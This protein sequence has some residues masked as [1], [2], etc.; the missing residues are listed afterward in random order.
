MTRRILVIVAALVFATPAL[1]VVDFNAVQ[2]ANVKVVSI[3]YS[4]EVVRAMALDI[5]VDSNTT[6]AGISSYKTGES[7]AASKGYG[8]FPGRFRDYIDAANP[9]WADPNYTPVAPAGDPDA[10]GGIGTNGVT[11]E[12]GSLYVGEPNKPATSGTLCKLLLSTT[13]LDCNMTVAAN[14][15]RGR[16]V[17]EDANEAST[18]LSIVRKLVFLTIPPAPQLLYG[19]YDSDCNVPVYWGPSPTATSYDLE[20][21]LGGGA[22]ANVYTG[23][24]LYKLDNTNSVVGMYRYRARATN[25]IGPSA[26]TTGPNE[27]NVILSTC[28]RT[29]ADPN[30]AEWVAM[31]RPRCWCA[32]P[33]SNGYQCDG[34][35]AGVTS[36]AQYRVYND[37]L[38][39]LANNWKKTA[40]QLAADPNTTVTPATPVAGLIIHGACGDVTHNSSGA[41]YRVYNDDLLVL[42]GKWKYKN[43]QLPGNCPR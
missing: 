30:Y 22:Y 31:G 36:G 7:T 12:L 26:W 27:V 41:N 10:R 13:S 33:D 40:A 5:T 14:A 39:I 42:S 43:T 18:N 15:T 4:G 34:D 29:P 32:P 20:R 28:Y 11:I 6:I 16:V 25:A 2:D 17:K 3:T 35:A 37:D 38:L 8:I 1:A 9:N 23:A 19:R 21:S 24:A